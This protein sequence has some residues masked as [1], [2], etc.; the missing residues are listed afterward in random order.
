MG[1]QQLISNI[2]QL[3][4]IDYNSLNTVLEGKKPTNIIC[5]QESQFYVN[6]TIIEQSTSSFVNL[7]LVLKA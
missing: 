6:R 2:F 5:S 3:K 1:S 7:F 4:V